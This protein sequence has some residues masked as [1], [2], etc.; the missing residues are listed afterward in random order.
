MSWHSEDYKAAGAKV[1]AG[2][3]NGFAFAASHPI[4]T[5]AVCCILFGL[6]VGYMAHAK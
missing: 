5:L 2:I 3:I 6:V 4:V 1:K